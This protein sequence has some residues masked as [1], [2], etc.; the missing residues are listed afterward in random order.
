M[1]TPPLQ[2]LIARLEK[3][4]YRLHYT[5]ESVKHYRI[6]WKRIVTF[7]ENEGVDYFTEEVGMRF[8]D[9]QYNFFELEE[10]GELKQSIINA[11]RVVRM[12]GDFQQHG[13]ILRR[14]YKQKELLHND[15][16]KDILQHYINHCRYK[17]YSKATQ[18][19]YRKISEKFLSF[20]ESQEIVSYSDIT[21]KHV[22]GYINTLLGY[23]YKTVELQ[24]CGLR[25]FL[26]YLHTNDLHPQD[27]AETIP[28]L[29][30]R[31]QNRIPSVWTSEHV[32]KLI[33]V[34]DRGNPAGKRDYAM[35]LLVARLGLRTMD[36]KH[37]KLDNLKWSDN[38]IE[39]IQSKTSGVLS[40]PLLADVGWAIIDYLKNGRPKVDCPYVF[41]RHLAPLEPF[42]DEDRLHQIVV[43]YMRLAKIP[44]SPQK[45]RGMHSLRHTLASRLLQENTPLSVISDILGHISSDST[46]VYLKVD[47]EML[48]ECALNPEEVFGS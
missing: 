1:N 21:A 7:F 28:T 6:E 3:E 26:R 8:L 48:R 11:F 18:D 16:S 38:R 10:A 9:K 19:H 23:S 39:L 34:I 42:S 33:D 46:A 25:S 14:Y 47:V 4:L 31:K 32:A 15:E 35:I 24:L 5:E 37:L 17:D 43:K 27:L 20:V 13:S 44:I 12:L 22:S 29:K 36:I 40:L 30:A 41:L 2:D 45:K